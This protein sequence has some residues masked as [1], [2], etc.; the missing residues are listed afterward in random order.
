MVVQNG[1]RTY[2]ADIFV[3][4]PI[5]IIRPFLFEKEIKND[6]L[7]IEVAKYSQSNFTVFQNNNF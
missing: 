1:V 6:D 5:Q 3:W 2:V 7:P 4:R